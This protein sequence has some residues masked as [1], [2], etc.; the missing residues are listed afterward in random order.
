M[1]SLL[2]KRGD[3]PKSVRVTKG[4]IQLDRPP[5][6]KKKIRTKSN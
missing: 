1:E 5:V 4:G 6:E 2:G 3:T